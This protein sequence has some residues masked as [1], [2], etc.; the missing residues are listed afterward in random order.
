[1]ILLIADIKT[2]DANVCE[3]ESIKSNSNRWEISDLILY[4]LI[5]F[6]YILCIF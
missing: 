4:I 5:L 1:M 2:L 6:Q 3:E